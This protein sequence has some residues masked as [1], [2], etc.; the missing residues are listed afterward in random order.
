[1]ADH[2]FRVDVPVSPIEARIPSTSGSA[3]IESGDS[4]VISGTSSK[5][6]SH[7]SFLRAHSP[8]HPLHLDDMKILQENISERI[9]CSETILGKWIFQALTW[10]V[11]EDP[12]GLVRF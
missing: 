6:T 3:E 2:I 4:P 8:P 1:M 12:S 9:Y 5:Q 10:E 7:Q 11:K